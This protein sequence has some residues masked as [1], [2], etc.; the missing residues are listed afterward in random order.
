MTAQGRRAGWQGQCCVSSK[1]CAVSL[2]SVCCAKQNDVSPKGVLVQAART[3]LYR[4]GGFNSRYLCL[5]ILEAGSL[6]SVCQDGWVLGRVSSGITDDCL[7]AVHTRGRE[8]SEPW[9]T[10]LPLLLRLLIPSWGLQ[11][12]DLITSQR[13]HLLTPSQCGV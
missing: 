7:L 11:P 12:L 6:R 2:P 3:E 13:P 9:Q 5:T 4:L 10:L 8:Q 1:H